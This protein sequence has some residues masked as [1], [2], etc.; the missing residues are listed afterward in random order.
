M[1]QAILAHHVCE[2]DLAEVV[3]LQKL[4]GVQVPAN[5]VTVIPYQFEKLQH[6]ITENIFHVAMKWCSLRANFPEGL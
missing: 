2:L 5:E 3:G 6:F 4:D 1:C